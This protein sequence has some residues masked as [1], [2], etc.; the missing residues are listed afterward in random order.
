MKKCQ[1]VNIKTISKL[2]WT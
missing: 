2:F 1:I